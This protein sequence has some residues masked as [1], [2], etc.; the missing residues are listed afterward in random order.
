MSILS[1]PSSY[2]IEASLF[3]ETVSTFIKQGLIHGSIKGGSFI[4]QRYE[5][6]KNDAVVNFLRSNQ[7]VTK[8]LLKDNR[9]DIL[10][11]SHIDNV[12]CGIFLETRLFE[13]IDGIRFFVDK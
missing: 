6:Q 13:E 11:V 9:V 2:S 12:T 1:L 7:F 10:M 8:K 3:H 4:P 5:D